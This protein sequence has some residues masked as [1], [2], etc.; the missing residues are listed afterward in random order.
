M[1]TMPL[2]Q[3]D[4]PLYV[5]GMTSLPVLSRTPYVPLVPLAQARPVLDMTPTPRYAYVPALTRLPLSSTKPTV[6]SEAIFTQ[7]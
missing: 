3:I 5:Q 2:F 6:P 7:A 1:R 4:T